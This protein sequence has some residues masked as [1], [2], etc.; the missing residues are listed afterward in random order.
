MW[1]ACTVCLV[2]SGYG[3]VHSEE[4]N[5]RRLVFFSSRRRHTRCLSDWSSDVCSSDLL[6][7][8]VP[9]SERVSTTSSELITNAFF[10]RF[11]RLA[12]LPQPLGRVLRLA[13]IANFEIETRSRQGA[14]VAHGPNTVA[15]AHFVSF[16]N[17]DIGNVG[18]EREVVV[19]VV[20]DDQI[21]VALEPSR[22]DHVAGID[23][24]DLRAL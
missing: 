12:S 17:H 22:I 24:V 1:T 10:M 3:C 7:A 6:L 14:R 11:L 23:R 15:L 2:T 13:L 18:V 4:K 9:P 20:E 8:T 19:A 5:G 21:P 16:L